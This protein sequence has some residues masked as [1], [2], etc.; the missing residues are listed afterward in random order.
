L[1]GI[2]RKA[3]ANN[4]WIFTEYEDE[5]GTISLASVP[6]EIMLADIY[7]KVDFEDEVV[8]EINPVPNEGE[9]G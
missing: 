4:R 7:D 8:E 6:F 3:I 1:W 5:D 2:V 9:E